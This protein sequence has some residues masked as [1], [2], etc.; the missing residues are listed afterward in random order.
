MEKI[1]VKE[2]LDAT[3]GKL[4]EGS[5]S[6]FF[7]NIC[8]DTRN[9]KNGDLFIALQGKN[10]D[11]HDFIN[12]A[13][14]SGVAG[15]IVQS[16]GYRVQREKK[17]AIIKVKNT[18]RALGDIGNFYRKKF[19]IKT[20]AIT[21][22]NGKTTTKEMLSNIL[23][24]K[25]SVLKNKGNFN[26][27]I[28][29]PFT[30]FQLSKKYRFAVLELGTNYPGEI[31]RLSEIVMPDFGIFTN[32]GLSHTKGLGD[33]SGVAKEKISLFLGLNSGGT[34]VYNSDDKKIN[35]FL[36]KNLSR[37][38]K[39]K[40]KMLTY[41]IVNKGGFFASDIRNLKEKGI[42][43]VLNKEKKRITV[44]LALPGIHNVYNALAAASCASIAARMS[45][46]EIKKGL[47]KTIASPMRSEIIKIGKSILIND[48]YNANPNS[49]EK[50]L[51][52]M[53]NWDSENKSS[54]KKILVLGD[55]LELGK[56]GKK[57][58][59]DAGLA[60]NKCGIDILATYGSLAELAAKEFKKNGGKTFIFEDKDKLKKFVERA[61]KGKN[62]ILVKGSRSMKME[63]TI[64]GI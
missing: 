52:M 44:H 31:K 5:K 51:L 17:I 53:K 29:I 22:S 33:L 38:K 43:F 13:V 41:S 6:A 28:G 60:C 11:G 14:K 30:L 63:E 25:Y 36:K 21:G 7:S 10:F 32:V 49:L 56:F 16:T 23:E 37:L 3:K 35:E 46:V 54:F 15:I 4:L 42:S 61:L 2:I 57:S 48:A 40:L 62:L 1:T 50:A 26:N 34:A 12:E 47:E 9:I 39:N 58:H 59:K 18:L 19:K 24:Q 45:F 8:T 27:Q 20:I 64:K 55:M